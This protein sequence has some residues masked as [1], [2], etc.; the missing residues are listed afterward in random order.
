[1]FFNFVLKFLIHLFIWKGRMSETKGKI[2]KYREVSSTGWFTALDTILIL[3]P[4]GW[5]ART[6]AIFRCLLMYAA[7]GEVAEIV[8]KSRHCKSWLGPLG[9]SNCLDIYIRNR[10]LDKIIPCNAAAMIQKF[11]NVNFLKK[12]IFH[13]LYQFGF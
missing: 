3:Q 8:S 6:W 7:G 10:V 4:R 11:L 12:H 9:H 1:M 13:Y 2:E 5:A